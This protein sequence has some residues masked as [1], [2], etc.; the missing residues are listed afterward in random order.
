M[1]STLASSLLPTLLY[2]FVVSFP[3]LLPLPLQSPSPPPH[4]RCHGHRRLSM[5]LP[6]SALY[7][8]RGSGCGKM[9]RRVFK[10]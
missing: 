8:Q 5:V 2:L 9:N 1:W 4:R 6:A 10:I 3:Q 7:L